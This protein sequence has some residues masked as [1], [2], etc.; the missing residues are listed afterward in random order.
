MP[1]IPQ[2]KTI[3]QV[4]GDFLCYLYQ[5]ALAYIEDTHADGAELWKSVEGHGEFVL[6]HPNG[7]RGPQIAQMRAAATYAGLVPDNPEGH[8]RIRFMTEGEASLHYCARNNYASD[9]I[10]V[11]S[12]FP[13]SVP[14]CEVD[15]TEW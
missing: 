12:V 10:K 13:A 11:S 2:N 1:P 14:R 4:F 3:V 5:C 6:T 7:W 9:V 8:A 15:F